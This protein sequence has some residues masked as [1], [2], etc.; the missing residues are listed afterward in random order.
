MDSDFQ[1]QHT[2]YNVKE[3]LPIDISQDNITPLI[4]SISKDK[5]K[6]KNKTVSPPK[7]STNYVLNW[8]YT[9]CLRYSKPRPGFGRF[10]PGTDEAHG[11]A[12]PVRTSQ[13]EFR[14]DKRIWSSVPPCP[15][16]IVEAC[17]RSCWM[18]IQERFELG[19]LPRK[20][21]D[22]RRS[23]QK[24]PPLCQPSAVWTEE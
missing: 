18:E 23:L 2:Y 19:C 20:G 5:K 15:A 24:Q 4:S 10:P 7:P 8:S 14:Q 1:K 3:T 17:G 16:V 21:A 22:N 13:C 6:K 9:E 11:D 12:G